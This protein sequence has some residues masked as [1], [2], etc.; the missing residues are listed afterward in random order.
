[1]APTSKYSPMEML[2]AP[3]KLVTSDVRA[4]IPLL[5]A[6]LYYPD[7]LRSIIPDRIYPWISSPRVLQGL[8]VL[9][10]Y[11]I[12]TFLN[13]KLSQYVINNWK[14]DA[15]FVTS[16]EIVVITGASSGIGELMAKDFATRGVKVINLDIKPPKTPQRETLPHLNF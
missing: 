13:N 12:T 15:K 4:Q 5:L 9:V 3:L 6:L 7:K 16:Q 14:K 8:K 1:M 2:I 10:A 11:N